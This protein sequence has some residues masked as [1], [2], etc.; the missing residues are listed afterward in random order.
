MMEY[1]GVLADA[2]IIVTRRDKGYVV[3]ASIPLSDLGLKP[4]DGLTLR[5]DVGV[6]Y[7]D[8]AG[9][10]TRLRSYWSNQQTGIVDDAVA[11]LMMQP[12]NWGELKF[13]P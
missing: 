6:T 5:G 3:E 13:T 7:G 11:E 2:R 1:V 8:Q 9:Q 12:R 10:R 4:S